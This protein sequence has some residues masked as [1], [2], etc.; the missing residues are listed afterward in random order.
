[1]GGPL[2]PVLGLSS[3]PAARAS[4]GCLRRRPHTLAVCRPPVPCPPSR[5]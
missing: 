4:L 3:S 5:R 1:V 2:Q